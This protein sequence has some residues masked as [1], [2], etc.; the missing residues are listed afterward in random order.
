M[1]NLKTISRNVKTFHVHAPEDNIIKMAILPKL[2]YRFSII[3]TEVSTAFLK[4]ID[5]LTPNFILRESWEDG[6]VGST[7]NLCPYLNNNCTDRIC[8]MLTILELWSLL[9][10]SNF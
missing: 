1:K 2:T 4:E 6:R 9:K 5:K 10:A 7:R 8:P 3:P